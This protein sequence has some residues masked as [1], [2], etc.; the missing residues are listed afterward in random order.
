M[1][2]KKKQKK[3]LLYQIKL[4]GEVFLTANANNSKIIN[5]FVK[6]CAP[7]NMLVHTKCESWEGT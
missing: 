5:V 7:I 4:C 6:H 1:V 3:T 2:E